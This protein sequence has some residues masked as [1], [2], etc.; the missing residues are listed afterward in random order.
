MDYPDFT[1][2]VWP[3]RDTAA[4]ELIF[5]TFIIGVPVSIPP[6]G[7]AERILYTIPTGKRFYFTD[8]NISAKIRILVWFRVHLSF[9]LFHGYIETYYSKSFSP[10]VP[11]IAGA[12]E[13]IRITTW[14]HDLIPGVDRGFFTG[15]EEAAS[16]P[17]TPK[18]N[19]PEELFKTGSFDFCEIFTLSDGEQLFLFKKH[20]DNEIN[21]LKVKDYGLKTQTT[22]TS[23][24]LKSDRDKE[25]ITDLHNNPEKIGE[26]LREI[27]K[28]RR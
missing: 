20:G 16:N 27:E 7:A 19:S 6:G 1:K 26:I 13:Q 11:L 21:Y 28:T 4:R 23:F 15:W 10:S 22:L 17:A 18:N 14:N 2:I 25:L 12:G 9:H 3:K 24:K 5:K 8:V